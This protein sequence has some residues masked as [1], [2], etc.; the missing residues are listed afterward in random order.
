MTCEGGKRP[1]PDIVRSLAVLL[2]ALALPQLSFEVGFPPQIAGSTPSLHAE[3]QLGFQEG[4]DDS[5][6]YRTTRGR[7]GDRSAARRHGRLV[8]VLSN[9]FAGRLTVINYFFS[10][11]NPLFFRSQCVIVRNYLLLHR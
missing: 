1:V 5:F 9:R 4:L 2:E 7:R 6:E 11:N 3:A 10:G 8:A